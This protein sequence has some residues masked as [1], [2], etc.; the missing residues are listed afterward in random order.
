MTYRTRITT[1]C[2]AIFLSFPLAAIAAELTIPNSFSNGEPADADEVNANF[3]AVKTA[4]DDNNQ[5]IVDLSQPRSASVTY[6]AMGFSPAKAEADRVAIIGS[7]FVVE[8]YENE[9]EKD[10]ED[11][12]LA[13]LNGDSGAFYH[14]VLLRSGIIITRIRAGVRG[15]VTVNLKKAGDT[16]PLATVTGTGS[17]EQIIEV[18]NIDH[19]I[20]EFP[21]SYFIEVLLSGSTHRL[22]SVA[23]DYTY[24]EP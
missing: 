23:I 12:S 13:I 18:G 21:A 14:S 7:S 10:A 9:F 22:Y 11:G 5:K 1:L 8:H 19:T 24:T 2:I 6:S 15:A 17:D 16:D 3:N 4:V 20:E